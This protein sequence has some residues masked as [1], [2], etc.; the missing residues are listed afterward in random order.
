MDKFALG[1]QLRDVVTGFTG[2]AT[3]RAEYLTG[4]TQYALAPK[5]DA[6]GKVQQSEWFD[7]QR[8]EQIGEG[9]QTTTRPTGGPQR[10][11]PRAR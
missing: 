2:I 1:V 9:V 7:E 4:C 11:A 3:G 5:V 8:L 10:D 6:D